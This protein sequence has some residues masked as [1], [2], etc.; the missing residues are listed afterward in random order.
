[1]PTASARP[2]RSACS[3]RSCAP[4]AAG[5][6]CWART[7]RRT[8]R[9]SATSSS[10]PGSTLARRVAVIDGGTV[11]AE[12]APEELK[13][14][15]GGGHLDITLAP[16]ADLEAAVTALKPYA[17]GSIDPHEDRLRL[18]APVAAVAGLMTTVV[19]ALDAAGVQ[20]DDVTLQ[21]AS[22]DGVFLSLTGHAAA[23]SVAA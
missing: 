3:P 11:I 15:V 16:G 13:T 23:G 4:T 8:R 7:W 19:R 18:S 14:S 12:G 6:G 17:T 22:L 9:R 2:P 21:R 5:R 1:M 20:V 10:S